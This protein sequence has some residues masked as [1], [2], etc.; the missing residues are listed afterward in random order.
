MGGDYKD[1]A[2]AL[3]EVGVRCFCVDIAHGHH[4]LMKSALE[5]LRKLFGEE[6][7]IIAGNVATLEGFNDLSDWGADSIRII[8]TL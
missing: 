3:Y 2:Q 8:K 6:V 1:R 4:L 5:S 7:H